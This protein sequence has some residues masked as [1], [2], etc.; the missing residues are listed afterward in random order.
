MQ[1]LNPEVD[2][3][4]AKG[5]VTYFGDAASNKTIFIF[6]VTTDFSG[7]L[8]CQQRVR[9]NY[10]PFAKDFRRVQ[11]RVNCDWPELSKGSL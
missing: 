3:V 5:M 7:A 6:E 4:S 8:R 9:S 11:G 10:N 1:V 2:E